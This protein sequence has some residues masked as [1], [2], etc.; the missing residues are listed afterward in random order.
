MSVVTGGEVI[1]ELTNTQL[2]MGA[3]HSVIPTSGAVM[4]AVL[5]CVEA[6]GWCVCVCVCVC[7]EEG[8][9]FPVIHSLA[10]KKP[11]NMAVCITVC[12]YFMHYIY[13][14][15]HVQHTHHHG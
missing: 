1:V 9:S 14:L 2:G 10:L 13:F 8:T 12:T 5:A 6:K 3:L 15:V 7:V 4:A 11:R